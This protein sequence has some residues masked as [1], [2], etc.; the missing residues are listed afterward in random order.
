MSDF[1]VFVC[2]RQF[3]KFP[4]PQQSGLVRKSLTKC[5]TD[6]LHEYNYTSRVSLLAQLVR[7]LPLKNSLGNTG[8]HPKSGFKVENN[9]HQHSYNSSH[10]Q[11]ECKKGLVDYSVSSICDT[12]CVSLWNLGQLWF[13]NIVEYY[14]IRLR[15]WQGSCRLR[16]IRFCVIVSQMPSSV[17]QFPVPKISVTL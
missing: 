12:Y 17:L 15:F 5:Q 8:K 6:R 9:F 2:F 16:R 7:L 11:N 13:F 3:P 1:S 14:R 4:P 10:F